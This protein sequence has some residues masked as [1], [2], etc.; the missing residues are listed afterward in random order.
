[1][2]DKLPTLDLPLVYRDRVYEIPNDTAVFRKSFRGGSFTDKKS[3]V[4]SA[5]VEDGPPIYG[6]MATTKLLPDLRT[7]QEDEDNNETSGPPVTGCRAFGSGDITLVASGI[8]TCNNPG[9]GGNYP[10]PNGTFTLTFQGYDPGSGD[11]ACKWLFDNG[12]IT[13]IFFIFDDGSTE[14]QIFYD[15]D[16]NLYLVGEGA[17]YGDPVSNNNPACVPDNPAGTGGTATASF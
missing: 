11:G 7:Q 12:A 3:V 2:S 1:M 17:A 8:T 10:D 4:P 13:Y 6:V 15:T 14:I 16:G 5:W 9:G